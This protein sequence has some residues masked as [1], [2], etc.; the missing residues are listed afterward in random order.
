[1]LTYL[2]RSNLEA[3]VYRGGRVCQR[4]YRDQIDSSLGV[5]AHVREV[6]SARSLDQRA[7]VIPFALARDPD[8]LRDRLGRHVVEQQNVGPRVERLFDLFERRDLDFDLVQV[9]RGFAGAADGLGDAAGHRQ[10]VV[11]DQHAVVQS[12]AMIAPA[13]D[14][15]RVLLQHPQ[16]RRRLAGVDDLRLQAG[17]GLNVLARHGGDAR[18]M[19][20]EVQRDALGR[21]QHL[22]VADHA[23][24]DF[25]RFDLLAVGRRGFDLDVLVEP[26]EYQVGD[27]EPGQNEVLF[28][29]EAAARV[30]S[31]AHYRT[32]CD[33]AAPQVFVERAIDDFTCDK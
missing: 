3:D 29:D 13:A 1:M 10:M 22:G 5:L 8:R 6:D 19:L 18:K 7:A 4:A 21:E 14:A 31:R 9:A 11:F 27:L 25:A 24:E 30:Q 32:G 17:D 33:V 12:H 15:H 20:K 16:P 28:G 23:G 2:R 26:A